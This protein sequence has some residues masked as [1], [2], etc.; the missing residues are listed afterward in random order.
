M[1]QCEREST[2]Q[3]GNTVTGTFTDYDELIERLGLNGTLYVTENYHLKEHNMYGSS[4][5][6]AYK[7]DSLTL[8]WFHYKGIFDAEEGTLTDI[9]YLDSGTTVT[10]TTHFR[11][12]RG[13]RLYELTNLWGTYS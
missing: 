7:H 11:R 13:Q 12:C 6:G 4:R 2:Y 1:Q 3:T 5:L 9:T 8:K 10:D